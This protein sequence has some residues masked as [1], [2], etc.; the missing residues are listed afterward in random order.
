M[1][2]LKPTDEI[3]NPLYKISIM[4]N[5]STDS[6]YAYI[7]HTYNIKKDVVGKLSEIETCIGHY[8]KLPLTIST[9][10]DDRI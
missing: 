9:S 10:E 1:L 5:D 2:D 3:E 6:S 4:I 7:E 8:L